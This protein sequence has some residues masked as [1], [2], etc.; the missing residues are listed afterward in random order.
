MIYFRGKL[1]EKLLNDLTLKARKHEVPENKILEKALSL[2][3]E[4]MSRA[5]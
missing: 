3:L 4:Q 2:Y 1:P 5:E